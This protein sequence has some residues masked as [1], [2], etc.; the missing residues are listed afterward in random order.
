M[1]YR[2][3]K[4]KGMETVGIGLQRMRRFFEIEHRPPCARSTQ[5]IQEALSAGKEPYQTMEPR[6]AE[7]SNEERGSQ[8]L[9]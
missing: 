1:R 5:E 6:N 7:W 4:A 2:V 9:L 8:V 3:A